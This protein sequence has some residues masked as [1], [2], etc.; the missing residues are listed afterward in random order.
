MALFDFN[1]PEGKQLIKN[2]Y[3]YAWE[4]YKGLYQSEVN[5]RGKSYKD[6]V[7]QALEN[8][9]RE[10][11]GYDPLK[12]PLEYYLKY[13]IIRRALYNDL[14]PAVKKEYMEWREKAK[15]SEAP[16]ILPEPVEVQEMPDEELPFFTLSEGDRATLFAEIE[17]LI[18]NDDV[19]K[20][21]YVA[22]AHNSFNFGDRAEICEAYHMT[23]NEFDN[24]RRRLKTILRNAFKNLKLI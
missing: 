14:P 8:R 13:H 17:R 15:V 3:A 4:L 18:G 1:S 20:R 23:K 2:L 11:D 24:G 16:L 6:Y 5:G 19:V 22:I 21:I 9:L 12:G 7:I 10:T